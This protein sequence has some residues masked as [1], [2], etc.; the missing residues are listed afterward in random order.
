MSRRVH[1]HLDETADLAPRV[2][3]GLPEELAFI[4]LTAS[5]VGGAM[6][7]DGSSSEVV[8]R[9][10]CPAGK[11]LLVAEF[12][13]HIIDAGISWTEF[14]GL[15]TTL[16]NGLR[17]DLHDSDD[18]LLVPYIGNKDVKVNYEFGHIGADI[19]L[20]LF[21]QDAMFVR[22]NFK[23][24]YGFYPVL[25]AGQYFSLHVR[26]NLTALTHMEAYISG[27]LTTP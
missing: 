11:Q 24:R 20:D 13:I 1:H 12:G 23:E 15:G 8:Y 5:G 3:H 26:D 10:Y 18:S 16:T 14:G 4:P 7:V 2:T 25:S 27:M 21:G 17:F 22:L 6:N 9:A 19:W